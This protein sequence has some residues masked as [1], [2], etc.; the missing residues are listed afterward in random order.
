L[1]AAALAVGGAPACARDPA[2]PFTSKGAPP[3][4]VIHFERDDTSPNPHARAALQ[5]IATH[6]TWN[7]RT[8]IVVVGFANERRDLQQNLDLAERR[9]KTVARQIMAWAVTE[10]QIIVAAAEAAA[11]D[12]A[13][14][15][16][17]VDVIDAAHAA[18][19]EAS[20]QERQRERRPV[21]PFAAGPTRRPSTPARF[22]PRLTAKTTESGRA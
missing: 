4:V 2:R 11:D 9:A 7:P 6:L 5:P 1:L 13:G 17:E 12:E 10:R 14:A 20:L 21:A 3:S 19:G 18:P 16:C 15:R 22:A 8:R